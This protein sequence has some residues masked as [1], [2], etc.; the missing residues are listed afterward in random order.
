MDSPVV[1][2]LFVLMMGPMLIFLFFSR[3]EV[4]EEKEKTVQSEVKHIQ[5]GDTLPNQDNIGDRRVDSYVYLGSETK[6]NGE[7]ELSI[8]KRIEHSGKY[9]TNYEVQEMKLEVEKDKEIPV[10]DTSFIRNNEYV[11][12]YF[13]EVNGNELLIKIDKIAIE[14]EREDKGLV[15]SLVKFLGAEE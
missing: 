5:V 1:R 9:S 2:I 4:I 12:F 6:E 8:A 11:K 7:T 10:V 14:T 15:P 13:K 3:G